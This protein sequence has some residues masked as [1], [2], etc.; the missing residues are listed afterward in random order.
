MINLRLTNPAFESESNKDENSQVET[1]FDAILER[2]KLEDTIANAFDSVCTLSIAQL[3]M[4][5]QSSVGKPITASG[6]QQ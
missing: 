4:H 3:S 5:P 6:P 2:L 1:I